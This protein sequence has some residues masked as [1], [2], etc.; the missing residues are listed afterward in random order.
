MEALAIIFVFAVAVIVFVVTW[1]GAVNGTRD[2]AAELDQLEQYHAALQKK[3]LRAQL[4]R[5]DDAM[6]DQIAD[7]LAEVERRIA[8]ATDKAG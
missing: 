6:M 4:E 5:W 8:R 2:V 7:Q 3:A 1:I